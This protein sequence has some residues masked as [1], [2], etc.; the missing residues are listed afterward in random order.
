MF[1]EISSNELERIFRIYL[2][3]IKCLP[4]TRATFRG[5]WQALFPP[6]VVQLPNKQL[7]P[8]TRAVLSRRR[9]KA[10]LWGVFAFK[11]GARTETVSVFSCCSFTPRYVY[12][13][14]QNACWKL[15]LKAWAMVYSFVRGKRGYLYILECRN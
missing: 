14:V 9:E 13:R 7:Q 10:L 6:S 12:T 8:M 3:S 1:Q 5:P 4:I 2:I 11:L 15:G